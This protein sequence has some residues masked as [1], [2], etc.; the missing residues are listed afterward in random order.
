[1]ERELDKI[2]RRFK[3]YSRELEKEKPVEGESGKEAGGSKTGSSEG[4][5]TNSY[6][7]ERCATIPYQ[8]CE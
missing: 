4:K 8:I 3:V 5:D 2:E 1:M 7:K 6:N